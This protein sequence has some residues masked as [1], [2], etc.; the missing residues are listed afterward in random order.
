M[1]L[2]EEDMFYLWLTN[3]TAWIGCPLCVLSCY[4]SLVC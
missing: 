3:V 1:G 4:Y 2:H